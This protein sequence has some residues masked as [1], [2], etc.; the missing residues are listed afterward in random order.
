MRRQSESTGKWQRA[1]LLLTSAIILVALGAANTRAQSPMVSV[2]QSAD[3]PMSI[4]VINTETTEA[5][6]VHFIVANTS[7]KPICAYSIRHDDST[8]NSNLAGLSLNNSAQKNLLLMP[9]ESREEIIGAHS[10]IV[11][12]VVISIDYVEFLDGQAWGPDDFKSGERLA[13][14]RAGAMAAADYLVG[15]LE[16]EGSISVMNAVGAE[17]F[18]IEV[19]AGHSPEWLFGFEIGANAVRD[20]LRL[21]NKETDKNELESI[22]LRPFD[23]ASEFEIDSISSVKKR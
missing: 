3:S 17:K 11:E 22:L 5:F 13:G 1:I 19:P 4:S 15:L 21:L 2:K 9:G 20:R 16:T 8:G 7:D 14:T 18:T 6:L 23:A 12:S 10:R